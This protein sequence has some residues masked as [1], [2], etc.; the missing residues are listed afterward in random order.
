VNPLIECL[1]QEMFFSEP[2]KM[3]ELLK[4]VMNK[5]NVTLENLSQLAEYFK[6]ILLYKDGK[7]AGDA[8][9]L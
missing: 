6:V 4:L 8:V 5:Q 9:A 1:K 2:E 3:Q 7:Q